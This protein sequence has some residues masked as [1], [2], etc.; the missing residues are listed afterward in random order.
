M[1]ILHD[2]SMEKKESTFIDIIDNDNFDFAPSLLLVKK[3]HLSGR[4]TEEKI[5]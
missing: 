1:L 4:Q 2:N 5:L 3:M